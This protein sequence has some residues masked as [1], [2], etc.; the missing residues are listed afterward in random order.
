MPHAHRDHRHTP[1][2]E[3]AAIVLAGGAARRLA[4]RD[5]TRLPVAGVPTLERVLRSAPV[6]ARIVVG[7]EGEDGVAL[8]ARHG[9]LFVQEEPA[10]A[11][12]A[13]ALARGVAELGALPDTARVLVL[14]GD[15]PLLRTDTL[16]GLLDRAAF[17][18]VAALARPDGTAQ[19]LLAAWPLGRLRAALAAARRPTTDWQ[20]LALRAVYAQLGE[21]ELELVPAAGAEATDL[22]TPED[23]A[24][25]QRA[26][27]P[28][29]ALAQIEVVPD[30]E[31]NLAAVRTAAARAAEAG[32]RALVLP[33]ATLTPFGTDLRAAAEAHHE[34]FAALLEQLG[35]EH[36][37]TIVAGSFAPAADG[38]VH[39]TLL[40]RGGG[41]AAGYRKIH[42]FDAFSARESATVAP[43]DELVTID[44]DGTTIG[45]ATC[46]DVRFPAQ[47]Q[48]LARRGAEAV[49]LPLAWGDGP[50]KSDQLQVLLRARALD[51]TVAVLACDQAPTADHTGAAPHGVGGSAVVGPLGQ[52]RAHLGREEGLLLVDIDRAEVAA[53]RTSLP[54]L[55]HGAADAF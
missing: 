18:R 48:A 55:E 8:A 6:A 44:L 33:E 22:D 27:G 20:D 11:G 10:L 45:L 14:G 34:R 38:R 47:F 7:P 2:P 3:T 13:A 42:L 24:A 53:A 35:E 12:P 16:S 30:V 17:G 36:G 51:A 50:G 5:K 21:G 26:A 40:V 28:R 19:F 9:A 4:G 52:L 15:M 29:V 37:L 43:G 25:A 1:A 23:V 41:L 31:A 46:Y 32:A 39:N 49:V 54:V